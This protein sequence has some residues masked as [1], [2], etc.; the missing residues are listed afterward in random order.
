M[1]GKACLYKRRNASTGPTRPTETR[2]GP[3][4]KKRAKNLV[5]QFQNASIALLVDHASAVPG[6]WWMGACQLEMILSYDRVQAAI[7]AGHLIDKVQACLLADIGDVSD[8][9]LTLSPGL[10][11]GGLRRMEETYHSMY[12]QSKVRIPSTA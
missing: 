11:P 3:A 1:R 12:G 6:S 4:F 10:V 8:N 9:T 7:L 5:L 2:Q